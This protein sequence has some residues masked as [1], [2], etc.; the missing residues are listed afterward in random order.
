MSS[1]HILADSSPPG[2]EV[3]EALKLALA[4][5]VEEGKLDRQ[6]ESWDAAKMELLRW[7]RKVYFRELWKGPRRI[8]Q[9]SGAVIAVDGDYP[10]VTFGMAPNGELLV[11]T[12][13]ASCEKWYWADGTLEH[14]C[15]V[16]TPW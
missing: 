1:T 10:S 2:N 16:V 12:R 15:S 3:I 5:H 14:R 8:P 7:V 11:R 6:A 9:L 4:R 13:C